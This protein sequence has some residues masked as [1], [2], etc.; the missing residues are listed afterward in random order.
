MH[1]FD[2]SP[3]D[4][5]CGRAGASCGVIAN[6]RLIV[7][8]FLSWGGFHPFLLLLF[9]ET[10]YRM[11]ATGDC[12]WLV[13]R[14]GWFFAARVKTRHECFPYRCK[15]WQPIAICY[16]EYQVNATSH[17][18]GALGYDDSQSANCVGTKLSAI[19]ATHA[20]GRSHA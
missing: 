1:F 16:D 15:S 10:P 18:A 20:W 8:V 2:R 7:V 11:L 4:G 5:T 14:F 9:L 19:A 3:G 17:A 6:C 12:Y 13:A